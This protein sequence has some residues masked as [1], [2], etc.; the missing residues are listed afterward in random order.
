MR[1]EKKPRNIEYVEVS[2]AEDSERYLANQT[3]IILSLKHT[4][5]FKHLSNQPHLSLNL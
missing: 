5:L 2:L 4:Q 1:F 3:E